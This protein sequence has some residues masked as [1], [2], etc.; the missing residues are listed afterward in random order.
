MFKPLFVLFA[1][2]AFA[3][4][5]FT[6]P[7][8]LDSAVP[9][10]EKVMQKLQAAR[11][12]LTFS[13]IQPSPIEGLLKIQINGQTAFV[14]PT[15]TFLISGDMY[16]LQGRNLVNLQE[17][18]RAA[19]EEAFEP[20]RAQLLAAVKTE[21]MVIYTPEGGAKTFVNVFT[22]IDCGYCRRL[23]SQMAS[24]LEKGIEVRY[25]AFPRA[26]IQSASADKLATVWCAEDSN[27]S[28]DRFKG[29]RSVPIAT[30]SPNPVG[31]QYMLGRDAGVRGTPAI[32]LPS[33]KL[34]PGAVDATF[35]ANAL[36]I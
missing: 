3:S 21:D 27:E 36:G 9:D 33:G 34:I 19:A 26:G 15:G 24:F 12:D 6:Q 10:T 16:E 20:E 17:V 2:L 29:G 14:D 11:P 25:L 1:M 22:D 23:H 28:M 32:V 31:E 7:L 4:P 18:E 13:D 30:C 35:L 5:V 8:V